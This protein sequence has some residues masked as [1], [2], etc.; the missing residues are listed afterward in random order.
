MA[1][2]KPVIGDQVVVVSDPL[3]THVYVPRGC[4]GEIVGVR[5]EAS[6]P[7]DLLT[8]DVKLPGLDHP[9][10]FSPSALRKKE[11]IEFGV[12]KKQKKGNI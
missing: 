2:R 6:Y 4:V 10:P 9:L 3:D 1:V 11:W 7:R 8:I 5:R 12:K